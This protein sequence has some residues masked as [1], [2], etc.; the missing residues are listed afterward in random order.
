LH[1]LSL[2]SPTHIARFVAA[3][4]VDAVQRSFGEWALPY[5][6]IKIF[7]VS[8]AITDRDA[9]PAIA[10]KP[11]VLGIAA[12]LEHVS[13]H[14]VER[15]PAKAVSAFGFQ[16]AARLRDTSFEVVAVDDAPDAATT[17]AEPIGAAGAISDRF[18]D[19]PSTKNLVCEINVFGHGG[20]RNRLLSQVTAAPQ[21]LPLR[22]L[23]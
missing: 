8:P 19:S 9:S 5:V 22:I 12:T 10:V 6:G 13:P 2:C 7:E 23:T 11:T 16:T 4:V 17:T 3:I 21:T 20:L 1:L 14:S 15:M 18:D